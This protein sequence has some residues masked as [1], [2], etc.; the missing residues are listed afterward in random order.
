MNKKFKFE[1]QNDTLKITV[2]GFFK[3]DDGKAY[4]RE[5]ANQVENLN[6]SDMDLILDCTGL[7]VTTQD[8]LPMLQSC[9]DS[10]KQANFKKIT[11]IIKKESQTVLYIQLNKL[12]KNSG[13]SNFEVLKVE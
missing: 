5:Y 2:K 6:T 12:A 11:T 13:I 7:A 8:L 9:F 3:E 4:I 1:K 10:Y